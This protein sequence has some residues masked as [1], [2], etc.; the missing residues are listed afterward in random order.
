MQRKSG[1]FKYGDLDYA[2]KDLFFYVLDK[3]PYV[4]ALCYTQDRKLLASKSYYFQRHFYGEISI[5]DPVSLQTS[6]ILSDQPAKALCSNPDGTLLAG[7]CD[8]STTVSCA[9]GSID[10]LDSSSGQWIKTLINEPASALCY[11]PDGH[12]LA[13]TC[14]YRPEDSSVQGRIVIRDGLSG[15]YIKTLIDE[16]AS[17]LCYLPDGK[18]LTSTCYATLDSNKLQGDIVIRD[19]LS[20]QII[21]KLCYQ[22]TPASALCLAP[23]HALLMSAFYND[24]PIGTG[25]SVMHWCSNKQ[26]YRQSQQAFVNLAIEVARAYSSA[27]ENK[28][29]AHL[30]IFP[31]EIMWLIILECG[32]TTLG[33][34]EADLIQCFQLILQNFQFRQN[35]IAKGKYDPL[36]MPEKGIYTWW[37]QVT[38]DEKQ[39]R[40]FRTPTLFKQSSPKPIEE[41]LNHEPKKKKHHNKCW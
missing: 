22:P 10:V 7:N 30:A 25:I 31:I 20:G 27:I 5:L 13:S 3:G 38:R 33:M 39:K 23:D 37:S 9:V 41:K 2:C 12:L 1:R 18:L 34:D 21:R 32:K 36:S 26:L 11:R 6:R 35:L 15:K 24:I 17:A 14:Y 16:P 8:Y 29:K 19:P 4:S 28:A 40:I